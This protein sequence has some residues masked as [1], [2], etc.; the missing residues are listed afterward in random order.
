MDWSSKTQM[1]AGKEVIQLQKYGESEVIHK[2]DAWYD[3]NILFKSIC[4]DQRALTFFKLLLRT[5]I[6]WQA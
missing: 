4:K 2:A 3:W 1:K 6:A 5:S